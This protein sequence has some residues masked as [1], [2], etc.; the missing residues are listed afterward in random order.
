[1]DGIVI[2]II[3]NREVLIFVVDVGFEMKAQQRL[4]MEA[5]M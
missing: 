3:D 1:V 4:G 2:G 5:N